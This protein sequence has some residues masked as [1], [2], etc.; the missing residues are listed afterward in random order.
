[1]LRKSARQYAHVQN[2][3]AQR[4]AR[5]VGT[6]APMPDYVEPL[7]ATEGPPPKGGKD[8]RGTATSSILQGLARGF[9]IR[10]SQI[11]RVEAK[12]D[13]LHSLTRGDFEL[14]R[15]HLLAEKFNPLARLYEAG[16]TIERLYFLD[17][18]VVSLVVPLSGGAMI[19][20]ALIGYDGVIGGAAG[21][22]GPMALNRAV[23]QIAGTGFSIERSAMKAAIAASM[24]LRIKLYQHDQVLLIQAQQSVACN[25]KHGTE[26]RLARSLLRLH[27]L[28]GSNLIVLTQESLAQMLGV[29]RSSVTLA[30]R[31]L[32]A[33]ELIRYVRGAIEIRN[34]EGLKE[35]ACG[36]Y[37]A[38]KDQVARLLAA[39][40]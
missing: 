36:C 27:D 32:Q 7:L 37:Q 26:E 1:M 39:P 17:S 23:V 21:L 16:D 2:G 11:I 20:T 10:E 12:N 29:R 22:N 4:L 30:A 19:E 15:G 13:F 14:L 8:R 35:V 34:L 18:G 24:S 5:K 3:E 28:A 38:V 9:M 25:A 40:H 6:S 31:N 33:A